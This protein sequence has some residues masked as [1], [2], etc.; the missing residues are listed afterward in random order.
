MV[1]DCTASHF[2]GPVSD[3]AH[4]FF[5]ECNVLR[6]C[7]TFLKLFN[8]ELLPLGVAWAL[9]RPT[10]VFSQPEAGSVEHSKDKT[11]TRQSDA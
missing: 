10:A 9:L 7:F 2:L 4:F 3:S 11:C 1:R 8:D 5:D 6:S